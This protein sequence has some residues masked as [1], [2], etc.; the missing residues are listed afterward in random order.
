MYEPAEEV[1][2]IKSPAL[3]ISRLYVIS[4]DLNP[5]DQLDHY[6]FKTDQSPYFQ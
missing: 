2:D 3:E 1:C 4:I 5:I 6:E